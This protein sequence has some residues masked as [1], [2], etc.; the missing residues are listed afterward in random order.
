MRRFDSICDESGGGLPW[1]TVFREEKK[2]SKDFKPVDEDTILLFC[3]LCKNCFGDLACLGYV[4]VSETLPCQQ[5]LMKLADDFPHVDE[6]E[7]RLYLQTAEVCRDITDRQSPLI[8]C[9][10]YSGSVVILRPNPPN[11]QSNGSVSEVPPT[12]SAEEESTVQPFSFFRLCSIFRNL[13]VLPC[14]RLGNRAD[15]EQ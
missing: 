1:V 15:E 9:G 3:M 8:E 2:S 14:F 5:L 4:L 13:L 7:D 12:G 6:L 10:V 11:T